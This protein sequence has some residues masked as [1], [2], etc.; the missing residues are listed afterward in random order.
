[1]VP[2]PVPVPPSPL[3]VTGASGFLGWYLCRLVPGDVALHGTCHQHPLP[4]AHGQM[5]R[6][7]LTDPAALLALLDQVRPQAIIHTAALSQ[8]NRCQ[9]E[10]DRSYAINVGGTR[11][12]A[13][14]A[15]QAGIP[16]V[17]TSTD[18]VFGGDQAPYAETAPPS[19]INTYGQHKA[20]AEGLVAQIHPRA[21]ICRLPLLYGPPAPVGRS[22]LQGFL[23]QLQAGEPLALFTDEFRRPAH[24]DDVAAGLLLALGRGQG[25]FH[26]SGPDRVSRYEFGQHMAAVFG[27][28]AD[29]IRPCL[30]A[31]VPMAA[32]RPVDVSTHN[33]RAVALGYGP[34]G[35]G[36]GLMAV[37]QA[38]E[39]GD[40]R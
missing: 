5:H 10:P 3:L 6:V 34:R 1:M 12:L 32:P 27:L 17:F 19:P 18:Q 28:D 7:S 26:L 38:I 20:E 36:A 30:Q 15:A 2:F 8:P 21:V 9:Q 39:E 25:I 35:V 37:R 16:L 4:L 23:A 22:F 13:T 33:R 11:T 24:V 29:L 31:A 40:G 14:Y